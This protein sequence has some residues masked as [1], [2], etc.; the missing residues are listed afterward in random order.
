MEPRVLKGPSIPWSAA[1]QPLPAV[2][3]HVAGCPLGAARCG[4]VAQGDYH[5]RA[6]S[7]GARSVVAGPWLLL[8][9]WRVGGR[10][11]RSGVCASE[12]AA[13]AKAD[14]TWA[15]VESAAAALELDATARAALR[16]GASSPAEALALVQ[17][18]GADVRRPSAFVMAA[19]RKLRAGR[20]AGKGAAQ[21]PARGEILTLRINKVLSH[22]QGVGFVGDSRWVVMVLGV[23]P[24]ELVK[25]RVGRSFRSYSEAKLL[26]VV[27]MSPDRVEPRC[28][29]FGQC[30][31]CD[32][33]HM[34]YEAQLQLK[35]DHVHNALVELAHLPLLERSVEPVVPSPKQWHYRNKIDPKLAAGAP[36]RGGGSADK[37]DVRPDGPIGHCVQAFGDQRDSG[38]RWRRTIDMEQCPIAT[39]AINSELPRARAAVRLRAAKLLR[40]LSAQER[41]RLAQRQ[42]GPLV[43]L[44]RDPGDGD[45]AREYSTVVQQRVGG[46]GEF[47][48]RAGSFFQVNSSLLPTFV[49]RIVGAAAEPWQAGDDRGAA[50]P[51]TLVDV[52]CGVGLFAIAGAG[53]FQRVV[54]V[55]VN[56]SAVGFAVQ[57]AESNGVSNATFLALDM[58]D[59]IRKVASGV[60]RESAVAIVDPPRAGLTEAAR[61]ALV[62]WKPRRIV[63]VSCDPATQARDLQAITDAGYGLTQV[64]PFD[65]FPQ[66]RHVESMV[67]MEQLAS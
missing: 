21:P 23:L 41:A 24:G 58:A 4:L 34:A 2:D 59:G 43:A 25:V 11:G 66:T 52:C 45:V 39:E 56:S 15:D 20:G 27:E 31:G 26:Q 65:L 55:E 38:R 63:Y 18:C 47:R 7:G 61:C 51:T 3:P 29:L 6:H 40:G 32:Y 33:Q 19:V 17:S 62:A 35:R 5:R 67:V 1:W 54:G 44:L 16:E 12:A 8:G 14:A 46:A 50:T 9:I 10:H 49:D 37:A 28:P 22:A 36:L 48:Y 64:Q 53:R 13:V 60:A 42:T 30:G 57:N